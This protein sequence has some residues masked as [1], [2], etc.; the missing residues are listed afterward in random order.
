MYRYLR[1]KEIIR[2]TDEMKNDSTWV[3]ASKGNHTCRV[4]IGMQNLIGGRWVRR[5]VKQRR[6]RTRKQQAKAVRR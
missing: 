4:N 1:R 6:G 2:A 5:R 3:V